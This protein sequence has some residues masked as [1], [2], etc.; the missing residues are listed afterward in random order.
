MIQ[1]EERKR[2]KVKMKPWSLTADRVIKELGTSKKGLTESEA[3]KRLLVYGKNEIK[4]VKKFTGLKIFLRQF[5]SVLVWL[6]LIAALVSAFLS[7]FIDFWLILGILIVNAILGFFQEYRS[8]KAIE[9]L[10]AMLVP[11]VKV[12][13]EG[14][15][16]EIN[17]AYVVPGDILVL[18]EGDKVMADARI[19]KANELKV[20]EAPLTGES[21]PVEKFSKPLPAETV[22][23]ER[24]NM[25]YKGSSVVSGN[26]EVIVTA[27]GMNTEYGK[28]AKMVKETRTEIPLQ[29]Y[30][31]NF[32]KKLSVGVVFIAAIVTLVYILFKFSFI[33]SIL[34]GISLAV[35]AIPEGL[36]AVVT[37]A[38]AIAVQRMLKVKALIRKLPAAE[39]LGSVTVICSDKTG[40][41]T[42]E[43]LAVTKIF[44]DNKFFDVTGIGFNLKGEIKLGKRKVNIKEHASLFETLK[45]GVLCNNVKVLSSKKKLSFIGDPTEAALVVSGLKAGIEKS[46]IEKL[47]ER[48]KEFPFSSE[49]KMMSTVHKKQE[50]FVVYTKGAPEVIIKKSSYILLGKK[51]KKLNKKEKEK[52]E[53]VYHNL[54]SQ[55]L[56][57]L[58]FAYKKLRKFNVKSKAEEVE[59]ELIFLGMQAML[60]LPREN[61]RKAISVCKKAGIKVIMVTGDSLLTAKAIAKKIGLEGKAIDGNELRKLSQKELEEKIQT[62]DVFARVTPED[63]LRIIEALKARKHRVAMTGDGINDAPALK[64]ADVGIAMG[65][66]GT[67]VAKEVSDIILLDDNFVTIVEAVKAGR[68]VHDNIEKFI[69]YLLTC[70]VAEVLVIFILSLFKILALTPVQILWINLLTDGL[71]AISFAFDPPRKKLMETKPRGELLSRNL[72]FSIASIGLVLTFSLILLYFLSTKLFPE[73]ATTVLFTGFVFYEFLRVV[74][75]RYK[76]KMSLLANK[77]LVA[78]VIISLVL[79]LFLLYTPLSSIFKTLPLTLTAWL[80]LIAVGSLSLVLTLLVTKIL[81]RKENVIG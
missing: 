74:S 60:D 5:S 19:M 2:K 57:V 32:S 25:V 46:K 18:E 8:E 48:V 68:N 66:R 22:L 70:N 10:K 40:T 7:H 29:H 63:K 30:L 77:K 58:A 31:S 3:R 81:S 20:N 42:K 59:K 38:L 41:I 53:E 15:I 11:K 1:K 6:L 55:G 24:K 45:C 80:L 23:H 47:E 51:I 54:A 4:E 56:R 9:K 17:S 35:A 43:E 44:T 73:L 76:E 71:P 13:R 37:I 67:E 78:A 12:R 26:A 34:T 21:V 39:A 75:I 36:P 69:N 62:I 16:K 79:Q 65:I 72:I 61:V 14:K 33:Q 27:T 28:I 52:L 50:E 64:K 49:R